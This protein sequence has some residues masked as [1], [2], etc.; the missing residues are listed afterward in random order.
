MLRDRREHRPARRIEPGDVETHPVERSLDESVGNAGHSER[1]RLP[2]FRAAQQIAVDVFK[3]G[4]QAD[5]SIQLFVG[6]MITVVFGALIRPQFR[7][8]PPR[9]ACHF[10]RLQNL[11][12]APRRA[13]AC[14]NHEIDGPVAEVQHETHRLLTNDRPQIFERVLVHDDV[15]HSRPQCWQQPPGFVGRADQDERCDGHLSRAAIQSP[16]L[17]LRHQAGVDRRK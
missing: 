10:H 2:R 9:G 8:E 5:V 16:M 12:D 11:D 4:T 15:D 14:L 7:I 3:N 6:A 13:A 17:E 1:R